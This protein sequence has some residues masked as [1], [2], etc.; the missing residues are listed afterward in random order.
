MWQ[1]ISIQIFALENFV[2]WKP[3]KKVSIS[4][5]GYCKLIIA[6]FSSTAKY[7]SKKPTSPLHHSLW[8]KK[9]RLLSMD[10]MHYYVIQVFERSFNGKSIVIQNYTNSK[11][12]VIFE[13][14]FRLCTI[15]LSIKLDRFVL[16]HNSIACLLIRFRSV[17]FRNVILHA[18]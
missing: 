8:H 16:S 12:C 9:T 6:W 7:N 2:T 4:Y 10:E 11:Q 14:S 15:Y 17:F 13:L 3:R 1:S 18:S 5:E